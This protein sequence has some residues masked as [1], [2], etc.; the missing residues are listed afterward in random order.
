M[1]KG[2]L[3]DFY[4]TLFQYHKGLTRI[5]R[6][7]TVWHG[8]AVYLIVNVIVSLATVN[9]PAVT[10]YD[11]SFWITPELA[12]LIPLEVVEGVLRFIPL[13]SVLFYLVFGP[14]YFLLSVAVLQFVSRLFGGQGE[15]TS[16]GAVLGYANLPYVI[17]AVGGLFARHTAFNIIGLVSLA[18]FLWSVWLKVA[19]I[20]IVHNF[21]WGRSTL[22]FFMPAI[23][24]ITVVILF[25]LLFIVFLIPLAAQI[26]EGISGSMPSVY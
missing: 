14:L 9:V 6:E 21:S 16:L 25:I 20:K 10:E 18:A 3:D 12:P 4:D 13:F 24:L 23:V 8:L 19:G 15:P 22:V 26:F 2:F 1:F 5:A 17:V 11:A 7:R